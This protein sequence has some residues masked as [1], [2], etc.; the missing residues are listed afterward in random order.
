MVY[1]IADPRVA[2]VL[3]LASRLAAEHGEHLAACRRIGAGLDLTERSRRA[4][5]PL[6][7]TITSSLAAARAP[8]RSRS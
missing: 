3:G 4:D 2:Q 7:L 5:L 6:P 1:R 8:L